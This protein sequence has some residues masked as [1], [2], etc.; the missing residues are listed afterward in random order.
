MR[1]RVP[2]FVP[3]SLSELARQVQEWARNVALQY[4]DLR[5][6]TFFNS[7]E[8][9]FPD[10]KEIHLFNPGGPLRSI[11]LKRLCARWHASGSGVAGSVRV[12]IQR[13]S[14]S[15]PCFYIE[16]SGYGPRSACT[17]DPHTDH[18]NEVSTDDYIVIT[19]GHTGSSSPGTKLRDFTISL[20]YEDWSE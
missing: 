5:T 19:F 10:M 15:D 20:D 16:L 14:G 7:E 13:P 1:P 6:F 18:A 3:T 17:S 2:I 9:D 12:D 4:S 8:L 11:R